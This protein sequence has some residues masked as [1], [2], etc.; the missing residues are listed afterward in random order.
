MKSTRHT[1]F[2]I[3]N[4]D[5][6]LLKLLSDSCN[7]VYGAMTKFQLWPDFLTSNPIF[8]NHTKLSI[9]NLLYVIFSSHPFVLVF[10][11]IQTPVHWTWCHLSCPVNVLLSV[12]CSCCYCYVITSSKHTSPASFGVLVVSV[13]RTEFPHI[14]VWRLHIVHT[15]FL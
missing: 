15:N 4:T 3:N 9:F 2:Y 5:F 13:L 7:S 12:F 8:H 14:F 10:T 11:K 1:S 6:Y